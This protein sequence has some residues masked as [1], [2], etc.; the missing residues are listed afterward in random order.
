MD[1]KIFCTT[2]WM[3][4]ITEM[5]DKTQ[6]ANLSLVSKSKMPW[7][8]L[9]ASISGYALATLVAITV[10]SVLYKFIPQNYIEIGAGC[11][12]IIMGILMLTGIL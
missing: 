7:T 11:L 3:I 4:F 6:L 9:F 1:W 8:V 10:G 2:F 12:F 5:G